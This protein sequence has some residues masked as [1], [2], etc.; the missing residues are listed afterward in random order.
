LCAIRAVVKPLQSGLPNVSNPP[1]PTGTVDFLDDTTVIGTATL[2][3]EGA[4]ALIVPMTA[5]TH[6]LPA[7]WTS[8][9][10]CCSSRRRKPRPGPSLAA[11]R[12]SPST[13]YT[14]AAD[15][16]V[17]AGPSLA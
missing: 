2:N 12:R 9:A 15:D 6:S 17:L 13:T 1:K 3:S 8:A 10:R 16:E 14:A 11:R 4:A 7:R 5:G